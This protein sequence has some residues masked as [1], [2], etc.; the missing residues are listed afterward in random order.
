MKV[1]QLSFHRMVILTL[2]SLQD[3]ANVLANLPC[4]KML[5]VPMKRHLLFLIIFNAT[6]YYPKKVSQQIIRKTFEISSYF[7]FCT[8][9]PYSFI[10]LYFIVLD[11]MS[12]E[13]ESPDLNEEKDRY[14]RLKHQFKA[15]SKL[16]SSSD[17]QDEKIS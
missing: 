13:C 12:Y 2:K 5:N 3:L 16:T 15:S 17:K 11:F 4:G 8:I 7:P 14:K 10:F 6:R 1:A 9:V